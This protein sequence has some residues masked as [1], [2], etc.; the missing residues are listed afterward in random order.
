MPISVRDPACKAPFRDVVTY[1]FLSFL[2]PFRL[3]ESPTI[4]PLDVLGF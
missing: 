2:I 4:F 3:N 1:A